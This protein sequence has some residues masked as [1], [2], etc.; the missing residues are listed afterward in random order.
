MSKA[1]PMTPLTF[2]HLDIELM[3]LAMPFVVT[4]MIAIVWVI[5]VHRIEQ[6]CFIHHEKIDA[7]LAQRDELIEAQ[8]VVMR[9]RIQATH[10]RKEDND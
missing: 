5:Y 1:S 2:D 8:M 3:L 6:R 10:F 4:I 7:K 9:D